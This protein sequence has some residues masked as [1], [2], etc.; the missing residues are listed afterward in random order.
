MEE[1]M[2]KQ[3][4]ASLVLGLAAAGAVARGGAEPRGAGDPRP[5]AEMERLARL[6]AGRWTVIERF[7]PSPWASGGA[8]GTGHAELALGPGGLSLVQTYRSSS[9]LGKFEGLGVSWWEAKEQGYK[10][11]WCENRAPGGCA[12]SGLLKWSAGTL[13]A[14]YD[15]STNGQPTRVRRT[16]RE[17]TPDSFTVAMDMSMERA[18]M[19]RAVT[20]TYKREKADAR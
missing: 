17:V 16:I 15:S 10:G 1:Q 6:F 8:V 4:M 19:K 7:E 12:D 20:I 14:D 13:V 3:A 5:S 2:M 18:P 11:I 9:S